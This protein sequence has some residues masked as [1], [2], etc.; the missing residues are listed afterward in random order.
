MSNI[1]YVSSSHARTSYLYASYMT[2]RRSDLQHSASPSR[3]QQ[4]SPLQ[5]VIKVYNT[6]QRKN[7]NKNTNIPTNI[8]IPGALRHGSGAR[9]K[10]TLI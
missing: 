6:P 1:P 10:N 7:K 2:S 9:S 3:C 4:F 5:H 8:Y